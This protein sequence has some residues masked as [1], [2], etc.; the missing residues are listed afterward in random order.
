M[1]ER[2]AS[3]LKFFPWRRSCFRVDP[4]CPT[5]PVSQKGQKNFLKRKVARHIVEA[6]GWRG[7]EDTG[8]SFFQGENENTGGRERRIHAQHCE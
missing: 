5:L 3:Q 8:G 6:R 4:A 1:D 7:S 2:Y